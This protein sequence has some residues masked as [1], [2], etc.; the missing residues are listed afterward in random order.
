[1]FLVSTLFSGGAAIASE[2]FGATKEPGSIPKLL[3][4]RLPSASTTYLTYFVVQGLSNAPSNILNYSDVLS[5]VFF[6]KFFDKTPRQKY[7]RFIYMRGL[8]WGKVFP[9]YANFVI[10]GMSTCLSF[11]IPAL[12]CS[13]HRILLYCS[14]N[15][16]LCRHRPHALLLQLSIH[17]TLHH[18]TQN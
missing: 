1:M 8:A 4:E 18:P 16:R 5:Y 17:A 15:P 13:S 2:L 6:D 3:A 14:S 11:I 12:T 9:K 7:D 10:I